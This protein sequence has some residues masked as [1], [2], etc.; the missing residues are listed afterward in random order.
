MVKAVREIKQGMFPIFVHVTNGLQVSIGALGSGFF[1]NN[2]GVFVTTAHLF[3]V[4]NAQTQFVYYGRL[5]D[6]LQN[7][8]LQIEEIA[9]DDNQ[10]ILIGRV[11]L[12]NTSF[13]RFSSEP[14]EEGKTVCIA[15]Y[16]LAQI[17]ANPQGG[18]ELGGVRRYFQPSFVLD[19]GNGQS[20][21]PQG[22][23]R[24]HTGFVIRDFGLYGMSGG[25]VVDAD[26]LVVGMQGSV[27]DPRVSS[28]GTQS[29]SVQNALAIDN[30]RILELLV[31][32]NI[33]HTVVAALDAV[34]NP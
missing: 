2:G 32:N 22:L 15:G 7:P 14:I 12:A 8:F 3:D 9:R 17:A 28:N 13:L 21:N 5:P 25:P 1:V 10:D 33:A 27:S 24:T 16:P 31:E 20:V 29:I 4:A 11:N 23:V 26:G 6:N 34:E 19:L 30:N 18:V